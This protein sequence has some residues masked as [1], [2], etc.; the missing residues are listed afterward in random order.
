MRTD[1]KGCPP[2]NK[3]QKAIDAVGKAM[4]FGWARQTHQAIY[5][6]KNN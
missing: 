1:I 3:V 2:K 6:P 4:Y 5:P